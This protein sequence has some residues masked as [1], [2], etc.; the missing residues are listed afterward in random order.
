MKGGEDGGGIEEG[1]CCSS[2]ASLVADF[3]REA[4]GN[5]YWLVTEA[6]KRPTLGTIPIYKINKTLVR[7][8]F[9]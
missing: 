9:A 3:G 1:C 2:S 8:V 5:G 6:E 7:F 4:M